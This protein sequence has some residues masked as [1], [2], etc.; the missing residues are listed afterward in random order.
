M[1]VGY[2]QESPAYLVFHLDECKTRRAR[3]VRFT[4]KLITRVHKPEIYVKVPLRHV[5]CQLQPSVLKG[6]AAARGKQPP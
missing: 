4:D 6:N 1:F 2:D 3:I 5:N